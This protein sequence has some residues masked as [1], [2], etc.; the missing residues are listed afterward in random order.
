MLKFNSKGKH[1][2]ETLYWLSGVKADKYDNRPYRRCV[3]IKGENATRT[4]GSILLT[5]K[6]NPTIEDGLYEVVKR[7]KTEIHITKVEPTEFPAWEDL[8]TPHEAKTEFTITCTTA[9][10]N[11]SGFAALTRSI[12]EGHFNYNLFNIITSV[13]TLFNVLINKDETKPVTFITDDKRA[14]LMPMRK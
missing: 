9:G 2:H 8:F 5:A 6:I 14:L 3:Q 12:K 1:N 7:T 13:D 4:D 10:C 11:F